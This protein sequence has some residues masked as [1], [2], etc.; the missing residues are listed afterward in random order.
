MNR[1]SILLLTIFLSA[2]LMA[3]DFFPQDYK[4]SPF[5][6]GDLL[7]SQRDDGKYAVNKVLRID[8]VVLKAGDSISFQ[9]QSFTV[10]VE[11][12]LLIIST[13]YGEAEFKSLEE[14]RQAAEKGS[15]NIR[16]GHAPNRP[17]GAAAGQILIGHAPVLEEELVGYNQ[18]KE[19]F[20][21][22]E[23]GVF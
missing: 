11:D 3:G 1:L 22:G 23:A 6:E 16:M 15:W 20:D 12:F 19:A 2:N 10:P 13:A 18:W 17:P 9:G 5:K 7:A 4:E 8:K 21:K 14:A